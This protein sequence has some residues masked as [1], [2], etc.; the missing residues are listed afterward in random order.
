MIAELM[1]LIVIAVGVEDGIVSSPNS[2]ML[3]DVP[4]KLS[5][6]QD[7]R[8]DLDHVKEL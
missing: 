1:F 3:D 5:Y 8:Y 7:V 2:K 6:I 4:L